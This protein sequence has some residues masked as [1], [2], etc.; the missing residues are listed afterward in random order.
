MVLIRTRRITQE[1][2]A[3][4]TVEWDA[5]GQVIRKVTERLPYSKGA[6]GECIAAE[7]TE[8]LGSNCL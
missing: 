2:S 1:N 3:T 6:T 5:L 7:Y 4:T 8:V